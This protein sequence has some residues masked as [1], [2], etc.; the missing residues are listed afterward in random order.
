MPYLVHAL[1]S[2][3]LMIG[4]EGFSTKAKA[5]EKASKEENIE[6]VEKN[7]DDMMKSIDW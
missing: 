2:T 7:H 6:F 3:S 1:K 4:A 5:L